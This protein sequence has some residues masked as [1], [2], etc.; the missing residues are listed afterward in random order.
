MGF[1]APQGRGLGLARELTLAALDFARQ[2]GI[3]TAVLHSTS[4]AADPY[5]R[6]GF[7]EVADFEF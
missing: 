2:Q 1:S 5:H 6:R 4:M 7:N 3:R